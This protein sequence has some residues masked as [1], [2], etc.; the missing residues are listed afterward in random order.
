MI[1]I[2][3]WDHD[4]YDRRY[5]HRDVTLSL[6]PHISVPANPS[7]QNSKVKKGWVVRWGGDLGLGEDIFGTPREEGQA[8]LR[9][10]FMFQQWLRLRNAEEC[11]LWWRGVFFWYREATDID[12]LDLGALKRELNPWNSGNCSVL[13]VFQDIADSQAMVN[14]SK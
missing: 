10:C 11:V 1:I 13:L 2:Y 12:S 7:G 3:F 6:S 4:P 9:V 8:G 14:S 5:F